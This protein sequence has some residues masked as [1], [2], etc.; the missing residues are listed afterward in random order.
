MRAFLTDYQ[1]SKKWIEESARNGDTKAQSLLG[2]IYEGGIGVPKNL[3]K[4]YAWL[5][6]AKYNGAKDI[7]MPFLSGEDINETQALARRCL[8]SNYTHCG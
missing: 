6:I 8:E 4:A 3:K 2:D 1:L 7:K 5:S